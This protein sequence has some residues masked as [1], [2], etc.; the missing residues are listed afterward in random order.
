[1]AAAR[2]A[3]GQLLDDLDREALAHPEPGATPD[4]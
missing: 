3:A 1:M 4:D 2:A